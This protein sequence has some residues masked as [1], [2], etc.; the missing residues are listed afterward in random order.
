MDDS[1]AKRYM[2]WQ[3]GMIFIGGMFEKLTIEI[4]EPDGSGG[5]SWSGK[6]GWMI[7]APC[8]NRAEAVEV[9]NM[10]IQKLHKDLVIK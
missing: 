4:D 10:L 2:Q 7:S 1:N 8:N 5:Y 6:N 9:S 3:Y